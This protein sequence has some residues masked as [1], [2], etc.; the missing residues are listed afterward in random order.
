[1]TMAGAL[2]IS[3]LFYLVIDASHPLVPETEQPTPAQ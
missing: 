3:A 2:L 1:M